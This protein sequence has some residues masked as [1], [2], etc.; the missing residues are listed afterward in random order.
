MTVGELRK[1]LE[2][3]ADDV[4]VVVEGGE[5]DYQEAHAADTRVIEWH[6]EDEAD[7]QGHAQSDRLCLVVK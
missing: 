5:W 4:T 2:G 7:E 3:I 6:D 1:V